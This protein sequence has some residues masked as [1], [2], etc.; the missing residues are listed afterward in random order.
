[1][2]VIAFSEIERLAE[3][4]REELKILEEIEVLTDEQTRLIDHEEFDELT[5]LLSSRQ[6]LMDKINGL[7]Q[8]TTPL[9]QSYVSSSKHNPV[10]EVD[11]IR[12][13]IKQVLTKCRTLNEAN[14]NVL[15]EK[16]TLQ[17]EKI[18]KQSAQ[19]KGIGGYAQ[20]VPTS[21]ERFD[22]KT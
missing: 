9:M 3:L 12:E 7:H 18:E 17:S 1:M 19:R 11:E 16:S 8:E 2:N 21:S 4:L 6:R 20:A 10:Y 22:K 5:K 13:Q 14:V 15:R